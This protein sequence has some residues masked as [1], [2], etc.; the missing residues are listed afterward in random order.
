MNDYGFPSTRDQVESSAHDFPSLLGDRPED[1]NS[2]V[3][4]DHLSNAY[5]KGE[6]LS[7]LVVHD[8]Q[9]ASLAREAGIEILV[10]GFSNGMPKGAP[11][12]KTA[13]LYETLDAITD[14]RNAHPSCF[15]VGDI[16]FESYRRG[17]NLPR[18]AR[19]LARAGADAVK[20]EG[21]R[22]MSQAVAEITATGTP[23]VGHIGYTPKTGMP[24]RLRGSTMEDYLELQ[25]DALAMIESGAVAL[26]LELVKHEAAAFLTQNL[27][28]PTIGIYSGG[29]TSGQA[30]V[31]NDI[32][33]ITDFNTPAFPKGKPK[34]I[35]TWEGDPGERVRC[36]HRMVKN[37]EFPFL[38]GLRSVQQSSAED[39][40]SSMGG[41]HPT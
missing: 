15:L 37:R 7:A 17:D 32:L 22:S 38:V 31:L 18:I 39:F 1:S 8:A 13:T 28:V 29:G 26:V 33:D 4:L 40:W 21:D 10:V 11:C 2:G 12:E 24:M 35:G 36:F 30:L 19:L 6:P 9:G 41:R 27:P 25:Q 3:D 16:P 20:I 34:A 23:V 5:R 14:V